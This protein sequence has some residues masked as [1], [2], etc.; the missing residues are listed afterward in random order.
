MRSQRDCPPAE[1]QQR[2]DHFA[3]TITQRR[4]AGTRVAGNNG[5]RK[6]GGVGVARTN[7]TSKMRKGGVTSPVHIALVTEDVVAKLNYVIRC[8]Y[9]G[10]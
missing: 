1:P 4:D 5:R 10:R 9:G 7:D 2:R 8:T 3:T 6:L